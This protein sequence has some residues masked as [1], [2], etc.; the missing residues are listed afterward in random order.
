MK[1][2]IAG[3]TPSEAAEVTI[4][5]V[6]PSISCLAGG[7]FWG[8]L[9]AWSFG[10]GWMPLGLTGGKIIALKSIPLVLP[11]YFLMRIPGGGIPGTRFWLNNPLCRHYRLTNR[12]VMVEHPLGGG[13]IRSVPLDEF[14]GIDV[15]VQPGQ[16]WY[17]AGDL[18]F[19]KGNLE[20]FRLE[21][22]PRPDTFRATCL[23]AH[24][25][26][27]GTRQARERQLAMA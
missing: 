16:A 10:R 20:T 13:V 24:Q 21:G 12:R 22:V 2:A 26:F 15:V 17:H 6:W 7:R 5:T 8:R 4:M 1:Q 11:A 23:K 25:G 3:V 18:V 9:Y 19:R 14:D 27:V